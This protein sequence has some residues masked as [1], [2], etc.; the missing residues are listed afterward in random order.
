MAMRLWL[1]LFAS[2]VFFLTSAQAATIYTT[3][4]NVLESKE[5]ERILV[6]SGADGRV[7]K[8]YKNDSKL[9]M[10][11]SYIGQIVR[12]DYYTSGK[13]AL[14]DRIRPAS[15]Y[16]VDEKTY[17]LNHFQYNQL[18]QFAPTELQ[19]VEEAT[20]VFNNMINDGDKRRTQCFKRAHIWA[21]DMWA[22]TGIFSQKIFIFYTVRYQELED[23]DWWFHVAPMVLVKGE[24]YV[25]DGT[26]MTKPITLKAWKDHFI[27]TDKITCP[28]IDK[29]Q[30]YENNQWKRLCYLMKVPMYFLRPY[31]IENRD[32]KGEE[33]NHWVLEELQDARRAFK[34]WEKDYEALTTGKPT[35]KF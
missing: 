33:R 18:R 11:K 26:F 30:D 24:E 14:I 28:V 10:L 21:Y 6:L 9:K 3:V 23:W 35:R 8:T 17:D 12:I 4:F 22:K 15:R 16:E 32:K 5:T 19:S 20:K 31:D 13:E 7:Y 27:K 1:T 25:F 29:Y 2:F 34:G